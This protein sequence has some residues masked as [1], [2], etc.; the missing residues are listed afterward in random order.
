[1]KLEA[2]EKCVFWYLNTQL[3]AT[4]SNGP[5]EPVREGGRQQSH[6][7]GDCDSIFHFST[8]ILNQKIQP[9]IVTFY[10]LHFV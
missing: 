8:A 7:K 3:L 6:M 5:S 10:L 1:M 4:A 9:A 2:Y